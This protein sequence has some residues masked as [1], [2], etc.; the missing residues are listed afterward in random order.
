MHF[1]DDCRKYD[2][3]ESDLCEER[4]NKESREEERKEERRMHCKDNER[5]EER[6]RRSNTRKSNAR[7][8]TTRT[9]A[10]R[11]NTIRRA[12]R[13]NARSVS[14]R[15]VVPDLRQCCYKRCIGRSQHCSRSCLY[16]DEEGVRVRHGAVH[17]LCRS[18]QLST[19][20]D[21]GAA[22]ANANIPCIWAAA[23]ARTLARVPCTC[24]DTA[25]LGRGR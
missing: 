17:A 8:I 20:V 18:N 11:S 12:V 10:T 9:F 1:E 16:K 24:A 23:V 6:Q 3:Q 21:P 2:C 22:R 4:H 14:C 13:R 5:H 19:V 25:C 15:A 7:T